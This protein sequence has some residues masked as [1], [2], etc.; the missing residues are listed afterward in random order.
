MVPLRTFNIHGNCP[1]HKSFIVKKNV[2]QIIRMFLTLTKKEHFPETF[3]K[4]N[5]L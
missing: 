5:Y 1:L 2:I 3:L 4:E